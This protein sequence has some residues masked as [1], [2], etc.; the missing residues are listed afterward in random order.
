MDAIGTHKLQLQRCEIIIR[1]DDA[2]EQEF[3]ICRVVCS[4]LKFRFKFIWIHWEKLNFMQ[5]FAHPDGTVLN[6][7]AVDVFVLIRFVFGS[8]KETFGIA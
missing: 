6:I 5:M 2:N 7:G 8:I 4:E 3:S 1:D